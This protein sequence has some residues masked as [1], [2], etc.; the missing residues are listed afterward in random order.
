MKVFEDGKRVHL[1]DK[2]GR[3]YALTLK[4]GET[5][6]HSG[7]TIPHDELIGKSDGSLVTLSRGKK[8]A[9]AIAYSGGIYPEDAQRRPSPLSQ[10]LGPDHDVG[11][12]LSGS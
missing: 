9:R 7:D 1:V 12:Y 8:N 2:K 6:Q 10:R 11:R 4:A 5:F 3:H